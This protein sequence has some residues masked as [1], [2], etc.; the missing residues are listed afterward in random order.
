M[1]GAPPVPATPLVWAAPGATDGR[2]TFCRW[3]HTTSHSA[4]RGVSVVVGA[5]GALGI[6]R[7]FARRLPGGAAR[8]PRV[9]G[10]CDGE[11]GTYYNM[12]PACGWVE[13]EADWS[14]DCSDSSIEAYATP[15]DMHTPTDPPTQAAVAAARHPRQSSS[16]ATRRRR[17]QRRRPQQQ[18]PAAAT[19]A[20]A[21]A[22]S[23]KRRRWPWTA[24]AR[25]A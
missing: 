5:F 20:A 17:R 23:R 1:G 6:G 19:A 7:R 15:M 14:E 10:V 24:R 9:C 3:S 8:L 22:A 16:E 4:R 11:G 25:G 21:V 18:Q 2:R 13:R 12:R